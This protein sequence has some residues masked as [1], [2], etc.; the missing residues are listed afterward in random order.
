MLA[1]TYPKKHHSKTACYEWL[2]SETGE[3]PP[4]I[5]P[6]VLISA[7]SANGIMELR[8]HPLREDRFYRRRLHCGAAI[9]NALREPPFNQRDEL[10][11]IVQER[12]K[13]AFAESVALF[14]YAG[15]QQ[16]NTAPV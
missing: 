8:L 9:V 5:L 14:I 7:R 4:N 11:E 2:Y 16:L 10:P 3:S 1:P 12:L 15:H 13:I 6:T